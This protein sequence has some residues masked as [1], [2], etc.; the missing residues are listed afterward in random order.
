MTRL[1][2]LLAIFSL[3]VF[4]HYGLGLFSGS[5]ALS[6]LPSTGPFDCRF[7]SPTKKVL[8]YELRLSE[9]ECRLIEY[10]GS[11]VITIHV[12]Y[13]SMRVIQPRRRVNDP[14]KDQLVVF[15]IV[16]ISSVDRYDENATVLGRMPIS[17]FDGVESC[18]GGGGSIR[19]IGS[20]GR[21]VYAQNVRDVI[22]VRRLF[23]NRFRLIYGYSNIYTDVKKMDQ[24]ALGFL[25]KITI[26]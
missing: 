16:R 20:D 11:D 25:D 2:W 3:M 4:A 18:D 15:S 12:E 6:P 24:F 22:S 14:S 7:E 21:G 19:F 23:D 8:P 13:P 10:F 1:K 9:S 17:T 26:K 5:L